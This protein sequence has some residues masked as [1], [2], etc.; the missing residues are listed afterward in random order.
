VPQLPFPLPS[1]QQLIFYVFALLITACSLAVVTSRNPV[2]SAVFLVVDLFCLAGLYAMMEAHFIAAIQV[3]VY[4]GAIVVLFMFVIMLLNLE[5]GHRDRR[6]L[7]A[8]EIFVLLMTVVGFLVIGV[9]LALGEPTGISSDMTPEKIEAAGGNTY[10]VGM[11]LFTK[12]LWPFELASILIL[13]A[14]V[15]SVVIAKKDKPDAAGA[16]GK[17]RAAHGSR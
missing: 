4:A 13:L 17:R 10:A 5:P 12:Y 16:S 3:L 7:S 11:V 1:P 9:M 6:F 2:T 8:P 15:A 14:I